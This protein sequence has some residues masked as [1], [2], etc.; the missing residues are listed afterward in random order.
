MWRFRTVTCV[1]FIT[2]ASEFLKPTKYRYLRFGW[3]ES[4]AIA[5]K[6][7]LCM[8]R[9]WTITCV[10]N[11]N[12]SFQPLPS[13]SKP[14]KFDNLATLEHKTNLHKAE[15]SGWSPH[16]C[17]SSLYQYIL[18][19][20]QAEYPR[21][22]GRKCAEGWDTLTHITDN[23]KSICNGTRIGNNLSTRWQWVFENITGV[24]QKNIQWWHHKPLCPPHLHKVG[25]Y[26]TTNL[27]ISAIVDSREMLD[28]NL[29]R[30]IHGRCANTT[31][32]GTIEIKSA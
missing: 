20:F 16:T 24:T 23:G 26:S 5:C 15:K 32:G 3:L 6:R 19:G 10:V 8:W 28:H 12:S 1:L 30:H 21:C 18:V 22:M 13:L 4:S 9:L 31:N 7:Q 11:Q 29:V 17:S 14:T 27:D 25:R 2:T